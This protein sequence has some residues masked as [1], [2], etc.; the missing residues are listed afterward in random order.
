MPAGTAY[1]VEGGLVPFEEY[2]KNS[3]EIKLTR[4]ARTVSRRGLIAWANIDALALECYPAPPLVYGRHPTIPYL[5]VDSVDIRPLHP[6]ASI[7]SFSVSGGVLSHE[8]AEIEVTYKRLDFD[9]DDN[10]AGGTDLLT[11]K[12]SFGGEFMTIPSHS[13]EW[14]DQPGQPVQQ[15]EISAGKI[16]PTIEHSI[17]QHRVTSI[18]WTAIRVCIGRVNLDEYE[19]ADEQTLLFSGAEIT[20]Q[21]TNDGTK[22]YTKDLRFQERRVLQGSD[23]FGWNHFL[24]SDGDWKKL[25]D[26][27]GNLLYPPATTAQFNGLF[28]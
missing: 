21:F 10:G 9:Q 23:V 3:P 16:I 13:L 1:V 2:P 25:K 28:R 17:T 27:K 6:E 18:N 15:E 8:Y 5:Y 7:D 26:K 22:T 11:R 24:R 19:G 14:E 12:W 20:F 4:E